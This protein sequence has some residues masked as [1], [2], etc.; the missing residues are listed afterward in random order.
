MS[1]PA[2]ERIKF[3]ATDMAFLEQLCSD[4]FTKDDTEKVDFNNWLGNWESKKLVKKKK[5][6]LEVRLRQKYIGIR[7]HHQED[8]DSDDSDEGIDEVRAIIGIEFQSRKPEDCKGMWTKGY[9]LVTALVMDGGKLDDSTEALAP[10]EINDVVHELVTE[11][12]NPTRMLLKK[13][14]VGD[15]EQ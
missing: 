9:K 6:E 5:E 15:G 14:A 4:A 7:M 2:K 1:E 12:V 13:P 8:A 11:D 10:Y 3:D